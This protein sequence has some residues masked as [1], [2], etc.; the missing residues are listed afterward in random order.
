[1]EI[2]DNNHDIAGN[3]VPGPELGDVGVERC[4]GSLRM[5]KKISGIALEFNM[6]KMSQKPHTLNSNDSLIWADVVVKFVWARSENRVTNPAHVAAGWGK[7][8]V[9]TVAAAIAVEDNDAHDNVDQTEMDHRSHHI[10]SI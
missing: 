3:I 6:G 4:F 5:F 1:M 9:V 8:V 7:Q 2:L 10:Q